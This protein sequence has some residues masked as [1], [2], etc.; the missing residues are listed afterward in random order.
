MRDVSEFDVHTASWRVRPMHG[1]GISHFHGVHHTTGLVTA[2]R[3]GAVCDYV[4]NWK[5][6]GHVVDVLPLWA[7]RAGQE[8]VR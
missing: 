8:D 7:V 5:C 2:R 3:S 4:H 6:T 1:G